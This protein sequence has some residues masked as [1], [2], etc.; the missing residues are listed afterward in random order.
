[1]PQG[2]VEV[3]TATRHTAVTPMLLRFLED[4]AVA[5]ISGSSEEASSAQHEAS[6]GVTESASASQDLPEL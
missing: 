1:M 6:E 5:S 3:P 2:S 4:A